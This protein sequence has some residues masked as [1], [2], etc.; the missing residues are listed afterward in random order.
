M[1]NGLNGLG[2]SDHNTD[3]VAQRPVS[4]GS[5]R[6]YHGTCGVHCVHF[7]HEKWN[8]EAGDIR[9]SILNKAVFTSV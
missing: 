8:S 1:N 3:T 7:Q 5:C 2:A 4:E 6:C 9:R